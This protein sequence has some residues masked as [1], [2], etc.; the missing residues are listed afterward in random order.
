M[1]RVSIPV[2][3]LRILIRI[4]AFR[5][6]GRTKKQLLWDIHALIGANKKTEARKELFEVHNKHFQL[7]E[8]HHGEF[9]DAFD[10][11]EILGFPLRSPFD[12]L[13]REGHAERSRSMEQTPFDS[14][15]GDPAHNPLRCQ[16]AADLKDHVG[17]IISITGYSVTRKNTSTRKG[18]AMAFGTF[19][20]R[21]GR[22]IDT[23][24]FPGVLKKYPFRSKGCYLIT[25]KV[26]EEFGFYSID[27]TAMERL[28]FRMKYEEERIQTVSK[29]VKQE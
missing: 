25:G 15:Q 7:P 28:E 8:L 5:F 11:I 2:E 29:G 3:Q 24:H 21:N 13:T 20:D 22:W 14:A 4:G 6:T 17:K 9:D 23:T 26:V 12:L 10:E 19:L 16:S 1:S 18:E 27:V